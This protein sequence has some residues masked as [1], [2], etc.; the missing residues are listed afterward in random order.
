MEHTHIKRIQNELK[1]A[2]AGAIGQ[3]TPESHELAKLIHPNEHIGGVVYGVYPGGL[4][5]LV[6]TD[7]RVIFLDRK[8]LF[9]TH[10][11][12][13]YDYIAGTTS[14]RAGLFET[15]ILH[16]RSHD[17]SI[18]FVNPK[19]A[20]IFIQYV[21]S[22]RLSSGTF[23]HATQRYY[24]ESTKSPK[25][26]KAPRSSPIPLIPDP[27]L[28]GDREREFLKK[29]DLGVLSTIDRTGN[30]DGAVVYYFVDDLNFIYILTKGGTQKGRNIYAHGR[31]A[32]TVYEPE[33]TQTLQL[34]GV[35]EVETDQTAKNNIFAQM[36]NPHL[37]G[38]KIELPPVTK[39]HEGAFMVIRI[40]PTHIRFHDYSQR[41]A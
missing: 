22:R 36:T 33:T 34:Q 41:E 30:L 17:Y 20:R 2:G 5:W 27:R 3:R 35:A 12:M 10:D 11:E 25:P 19:T 24:P 16:S 21:D 9:S 4:A 18:S 40:T 14:T 26:A 23:D 39:L 15:V 6:A 1:A 7:Q 29:H 8:P 13:T 28:A 38:S 31:I 37:Y 32:L